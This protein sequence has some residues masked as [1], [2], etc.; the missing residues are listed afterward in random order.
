VATAIEVW[1]GLCKYLGTAG[2][3][4]P[5][6]GF[7]FT[8]GILGEFGRCSGL[9]LVACWSGLHRLVLVGSWAAS[10]GARGIACWAG[11]GIGMVGLVAMVVGSASVLGL[12]TGLRMPKTAK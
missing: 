2:F 7:L 9:G 10:A 1:W 5:V 11:L 4:V 12:K 6:A 3:Q 8:A